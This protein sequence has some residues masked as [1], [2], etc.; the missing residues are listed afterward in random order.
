MREACACGGSPFWYSE[1]TIAVRENIC[2]SEVMKRVAGL[3]TEASRDVAPAASPVRRPRS[4]FGADRSPTREAL[5]LVGERL[6]DARQRDDRQML[7]TGLMSDV[8]FEVCPRP[9]TN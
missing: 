9:A 4:G 1:P 5:G 7:S 6:R 3:V 8:E 2:D